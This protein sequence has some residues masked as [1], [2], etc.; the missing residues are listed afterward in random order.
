MWQT[1]GSTTS[2]MTAI[3]DMFLRPG[4]TPLTDYQACRGGARSMHHASAQP[5][6]YRSG[7]HALGLSCACRRWLQLAGRVAAA[8]YA[9][10]ARVAAASGPSHEPAVPSCSSPNLSSCFI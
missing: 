5:C 10:Q 4:T 3:K 8:C 6:S 2:L 9:R 1:E 7:Q